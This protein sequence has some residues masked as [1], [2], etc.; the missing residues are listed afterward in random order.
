MFSFPNA[1]A[2]RLLCFHTVLRSIHSTNHVDFLTAFQSHANFSRNGLLSILEP[3]K[4]CSPTYETFKRLQEVVDAKTSK[5]SFWIQFLNTCTELDRPML[6]KAAADFVASAPLLH[7]KATI[8]KTLELF[9]AQSRFAEFRLVFDV[10]HSDLTGP[11]RIA[12]ASDLIRILSQTP[13]YR[14]SLNIVP[15]LDERHRNSAV[16][17]ICEGA[18]RFDSAKSAVASLNDLEPYHLPPPDNFF[19]E[20]LAKLRAKEDYS[21]MESLLEIIR[22]KHW[23]ISESSATVIAS[24]FNSKDLQVYAA[25]MGV[26]IEGTMCSECKKKLPV[27]RLS[28]DVLTSMSEEFYQ[29]AFKGTQDEYL[30]LTTTPRE[31][32]ALEKF[33]E[34]QED[35]FDCVIDF[36]NVM[37]QLGVP[38]EPSKA[39]R[40]MCELL[41]TFKRELNLQ[42]FC[43]VSKGNPVIRHP[44]FL[45]QVKELGNRLGISV[46]SFI[47]QNKS[48]DDIFTIYMALWSG[49]HC[50]L[51]SNDEF[52]Q[53]RHTVGSRLG[54]QI[55]RWQSVRQIGL[56]QG[57]HGRLLVPLQCDT[58]VHGSGDNGWHIPYG[59]K[60]QKSSYIPPNLWL[61]VRPLA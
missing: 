35:R 44:T 21:V 25:K 43:L 41:Q 34:S 22:T 3:L 31:L 48:E 58:C 45:A 23:I 47:T 8:M 16:R 14:E 19:V 50:Y 53:H 9:A 32:N 15:L 5:G 20:L 51:V 2:R 6:A 4:D 46:F 37:H 39:G 33:L 26:H 27:F 30:Y 54:F 42:R 28:E 40:F 7:S 61:C 13:Y 18:A 24:W 59:D 60:T 1:Y 12:F 36:L 49:P 38:F 10:L 56:H 55:S 52:K 17:S 29:R 11:E 57:K